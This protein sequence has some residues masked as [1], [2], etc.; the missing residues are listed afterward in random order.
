MAARRSPFLKALAALHDALRECKAPAAVIGGVAIIARGVARHTADIDA[1][2]LAAAVENRGLLAC[3]A[4]HGFVARIPKP[5]EFARANQ[6]VLLRHRITGVDLDL[7]LAWLPFEAEAI[8][9]AEPIEYAGVTLP[10]ARAEDLLIYK[11]IAHRNRDLDDAE[12]LLLLHRKAI[13]MAR[14]RRVLGQLA[15]ALEGPDR[16]MTLAQLAGRTG[17]G[18]AGRDR[19]RSRGGRSR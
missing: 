3:F 17:S 16:L 2:V 19:A 14:V 8:A 12:R 18:G 1:T 10:C 15:E 4:G 7:S 9:N 5:L 11:L 13:D 6:I